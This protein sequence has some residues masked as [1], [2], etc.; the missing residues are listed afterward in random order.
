VSKCYARAIQA[1]RSTTLPL[2]RKNPDAKGAEDPRPIKIDSPFC[3]GEDVDADDEEE[4]LLFT[5]PLFSGGSQHAVEL[6]NPPVLSPVAQSKVETWRHPGAPVSSIDTFAS[7]VDKMANSQLPPSPSRPVALAPS[8]RPSTSP[9]IT[10]EPTEST[11]HRQRQRD[12]R[13]NLDNNFERLKAA[14]P[15]KFRDSKRADSLSTAREYIELLEQ[16]LTQHGG[17][18]AV[19]RCGEGL[20]GAGGIAASSPRMAG[21]GC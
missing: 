6:P 17:E 14:L 11:T 19:T 21:E 8:L 20:H 1:A 2:Q 13:S 4:A 5:Q 7:P 10:P 9:R 15:K 18:A 12:Y 3:F 16:A